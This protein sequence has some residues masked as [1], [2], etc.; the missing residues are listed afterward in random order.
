MK[1]ASTDNINIQVVAFPKKT[2]YIVPGVQQIKTTLL[3][4]IVGTKFIFTL[5]HGYRY[6]FF[7]SYSKFTVFTVFALIS[8]VVMDAVKSSSR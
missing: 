6:T 8:I 3:E 5:F 2:V 4:T 7:V 1:V